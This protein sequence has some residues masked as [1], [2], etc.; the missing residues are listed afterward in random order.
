MFEEFFLGHFDGVVGGGVEI[1]SF[2]G[3]GEIEGDSVGRHEARRGGS[4][5][6]GIAA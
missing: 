6:A 2:E 4:S 1:V 3:A 5:E